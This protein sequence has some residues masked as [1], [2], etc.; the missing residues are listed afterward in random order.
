MVPVTP[1]SIFGPKTILEEKCWPA[2]GLRP[3]MDPHSVSSCFCHLDQAQT[4]GQLSWDL[5]IPF[6]VNKSQIRATEG[7]FR[8]RWKCQSA[9]V[10]PS[11]FATWKNSPFS[12]GLC[13]PHQESGGSAQSLVFRPGFWVCE[14]RSPMSLPAG[15]RGGNTQ[16]EIPG[17]YLGS[18]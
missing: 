10:C 12:P 13:W 18:Y 3:G 11:V 7:H 16:L 2:C 14:W 17:F 15:K 1:S 9:P 5:L 6:R 4:W 8:K